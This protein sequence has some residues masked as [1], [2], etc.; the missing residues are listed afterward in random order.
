MSRYVLAVIVGAVA[1]LASAV[2]PAELRSIARFGLDS[3][4]QAVPKGCKQNPD[5]TLE[6]KGS[7]PNLRAGKSSGSGAIPSQNPRKG[8]GSSGPAKRNLNSSKSN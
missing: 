1:L 7:K 4:A 5:G 6:C 3:T 2:V 8:P